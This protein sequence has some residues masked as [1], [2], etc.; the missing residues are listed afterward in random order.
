LEASLQGC[1]RQTER[2]YG[3]IINLTRI[4]GE[5]RIENEEAEIDKVGKESS[6]VEGKD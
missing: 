4:I 5:R 2:T 1:Q 3:A 6:S